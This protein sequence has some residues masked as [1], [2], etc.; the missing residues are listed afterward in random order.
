MTSAHAGNRNP[1]AGPDSAG[2]KRAVWLLLAL[3]G[4]I[5]FWLGAREATWQAAVEPAQILAGLVE[6]PRN[7]PFYMHQSRIWTVLHQLGAICLSCGISERTLSLLTSGIL[8]MFI[9]QA[10]SMTV[11][12]F[13]RGLLI[14]LLGPFF[15]FLS[16]A[17]DF[18]AT[19]P[20]LL[21]GYNHTYGILALAYAV[22]VL[23]LFGAEQIALG[24]FLLGFAPAVHPP[25]GAFL[26]MAVLIGLAWKKNDSAWIRKRGVAAFF[27]GTALMVLSLLVHLVISYDVPGV[28]REVTA[29]YMNAFIK[30]WDGHRQPADL[31][32]LGAALNFYYLGMGAL[33]LLFSGR[34]LS[35]GPEFFLRSTMVM[36]FLGVCAAL[37][38]H[39]P[40][41]RLPNVFFELMPTRML[42]VATFCFMS[43]LIGTLYGR[44]GSLAVQGVLLIVLADTLYF[45]VFGTYKIMLVAALLALI[46][47]ILAS[48]K[49]RPEKRRDAGVAAT[50]MGL[51]LFPFLTHSLGLSGPYGRKV[52]LAAGLA[53]AAYLFIRSVRPLRRID[54]WVFADR[55]GSWM[56]DRAKALIPASRAAILGGL[57]LAAVIFLGQ[58]RTDAHFRKYTLK[59]RANDAVLAA[60]STTPGLL[61]LSPELHLFQLRTR[62][63]VLLDPEYLDMLP[64]TPQVGPELDHILTGVYGINLFEPPA[65][66]KEKRNG[67]LPKNAGRAI[68]EGRSDMD[69]RQ[70][71]REFGVSQVISPAEWR[72]HLPVEAKSKTLTLYGIPAAGGDGAATEIHAD[73]KSSLPRRK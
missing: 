30:Y 5:G 53:L 18:G 68:W 2:Q 47:G 16:G 1:Y 7:N 37:L 73:T 49:S 56:R 39:L 31:G 63:P 62:R 15:V 64:Y 46:L 26:W 45:R 29:R 65:E 17:T 14:S 27:L 6:Y 52:G 44:K 22:L 40:P 70:I 11:F 33:W 10:L 55:L 21:M 4:A 25:T 42:N 54:P 34:K 12:V 60:A 24:A 20:I 69:W 71:R 61:L 59:N 66:L 50:A 38:S 41:E 32:S 23:A 35:R 72:L 19:Y 8:G 43:I 67:T 13:S 48:L 51:L 9:Y 57:A 3:G 28:S 58:D 36:A